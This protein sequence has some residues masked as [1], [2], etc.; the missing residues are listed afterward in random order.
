MIPFC[1]RPQKTLDGKHLTKVRLCCRRQR[2]DA[3]F[4]LGQ[5]GG[6][7]VGPLIDELRREAAVKADW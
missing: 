4:K 3:A 1:A 7:A 6:A 5:L 2:L